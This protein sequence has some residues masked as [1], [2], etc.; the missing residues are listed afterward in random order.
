M[1]AAIPV[2]LAV[3]STAATVYSAYSSEQSA[4]KSEKRNERALAAQA[5][6]ERQAAALRASDEEK[7][8]RRILASQRARYGALGMEY[9]GSPVDVQIASIQESEEQIKRIL[10][11]GD[12]TASMLLDES[13]W[14]GRLAKQHEGASYIG[15]GTALVSGVNTVGKAM[16]WWA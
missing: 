7:R 12:Y 2:I 14:R 5:N 4:E 1:A 6:R 9:E 3:V 10:E 16:K 13:R 15:A 11:G 8:H